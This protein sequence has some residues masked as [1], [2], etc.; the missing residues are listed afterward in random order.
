MDT[1]AFAAIAAILIFVAF[2]NPNIVAVALEALEMLP[3]SAS[4]IVLTPFGLSL[5]S[6][7]VCRRLCD[8]KAPI[9]RSISSTRQQLCGSRKEALSMAGVWGRR[10]CRG[11]KRTYGKLPSCRPDRAIAWLCSHRD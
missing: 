9:L 6:L 2:G 1:V 4:R 10:K 3:A 11:L 7:T 5:A 8:H